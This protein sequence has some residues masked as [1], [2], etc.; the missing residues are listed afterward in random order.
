M[1]T[2]NNQKLFKWFTQV[3]PQRTR[4]VVLPRMFSDSEGALDCRQLVAEPVSVANAEGM[5]NRNA[6]VATLSSRGGAG[7]ASAAQPMPEEEKPEEEA[8]WCTTS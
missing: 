3:F 1:T 4:I 7:G 5:A 8:G 6:P 2:I